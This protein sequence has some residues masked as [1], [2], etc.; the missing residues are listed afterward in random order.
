MKS[1]TGIIIIT[2]GIIALLITQIVNDRLSYFGMGAIGIIVVGLVWMFFN[3]K[4]S[5]QKFNFRKTDSDDN[6]TKCKYY[7][8]KS[9]DGVQ[10][11]VNF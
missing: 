5:K 1:Y 3:S 2:I 8:A 7:V 6:C 9:F 4:D 10:Q 11:I